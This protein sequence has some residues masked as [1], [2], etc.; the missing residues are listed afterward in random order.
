MIQKRTIYDFCGNVFMIYGITMGILATLCLIVGEDAAEVSTIFA[1][2][3]K[4]LSITTMLQFFLMVVFLVGFEWLF[5]TDLLIKNWSLVARTVAMFAMV[6]MT[7]GVFAAIFKW[8][9]VGM[10]SAWVAFLI[11]FFVCAVVSIAVSV[12]KERNENK[13][14]QEALERLALEVE[15]EGEEDTWEK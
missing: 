3:N 1:M 10:V 14:M 5:F 4:G 2:G 8:F 15:G 9:P 13:K 11:C 6:I 7:V 12:L